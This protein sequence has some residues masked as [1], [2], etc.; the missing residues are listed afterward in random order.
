MK[1]IGRRLQVGHNAIKHQHYFIGSGNEVRKARNR[2]DLLKTQSGSLAMMLGDQQILPQPPCKD[3][4]AFAPKCGAAID[5]MGQHGTS[6]K[7]A[8]RKPLAG[9]VWRFCKR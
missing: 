5:L 4:Y 1:R 9:P 3:N 2:I 6:G 8:M 7:P